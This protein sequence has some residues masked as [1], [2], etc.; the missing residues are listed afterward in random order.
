[1]NESEQLASEIKQRISLLANFDGDSLKE[2]MDSLR[3]ALSQNP[4][5]CELLLPED[6]GLAVAA[7]KRMV[8][9]AVAESNSPEKKERK[10]KEKTMSAKELQAALAN[11]SDDE[12][13]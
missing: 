9:K 2:E 13:D 7:L 3:T 1:M 8:G 11:I 6:I 10:K 5:A 12:L 4:A